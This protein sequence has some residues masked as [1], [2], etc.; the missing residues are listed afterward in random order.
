MELYQIKYFLALSETLN[1][2]RAAEQCHV[3]QPSLT[4]AVQ[5]LEEELGGVLF[6]RERA[7]THLTELGRS[8]LPFLKKSLE[9]AEAAKH[10]AQC[11]GSGEVAPLKLGMSASIDIDM[12]MPKLREL[13]RAMP[14]LKLKMVRGCADSLMQQLEEGELELCI[15]ATE[16]TKWERVDQWQ[17]FTEAFRLLASPNHPVST[18]KKVCLKDLEGEQLVS[19]ALCEHFKLL[20]GRLEGCNISLSHIHELSDPSDFC[21]FVEGALGVGIAPSSMQHSDKTVSI[22]L[23]EPGLVRTVSLFAVAGRQYSPAAAT[24][25]RMMRAAEWPADYDA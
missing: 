3:S 23:D 21:A 16:E 15:T 6:R 9:S 10:H 2:T 17:L 1:F 25:I 4:R 13:S 18:A 8:M 24:F 19:N 14:G 5:K 12:I 20:A 22:A 7:R 11:Y